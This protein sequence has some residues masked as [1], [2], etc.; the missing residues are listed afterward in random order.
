MTTESET[1]DQGR[2]SMFRS[3]P[4]AAL[5]MAVPGSIATV[6]SADSELLQLG[7]SLGEAWASE[8]QAYDTEDWEQAELA[9]NLASSLVARIQGM[10]AHT[11]EGLRVKAQ[12]LVWCYSGG[13]VQLP[14]SDTTNMKLVQGIIADL[15]RAVA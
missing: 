5:M 9:S 12:A 11:I 7:Y 13:E 6:T 14:N 8:E 2:R 1:V 15:L 10:P 3:L 4:Y